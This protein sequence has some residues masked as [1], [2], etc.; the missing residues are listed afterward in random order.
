MSIQIERRIRAAE[1][2][3]AATQPSARQVKI[4]CSPP[5]DSDE[6]EVARFSAEV[7]QAVR[8]GFFVVKLVSLKPLEPKEAMQ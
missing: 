6:T 8:D 1:K 4:M 5:D 7:E 3:V 2:T